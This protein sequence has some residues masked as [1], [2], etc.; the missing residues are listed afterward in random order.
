MKNFND[1]LKMNSFDNIN[2]DKT[3]NLYLEG[4][5]SE[6]QWE[7]YI[8]ESLNE[9]LNENLISDWYGQMKTWVTEKIIP[10]LKSFYEKIMNNTAGAYLKLKSFLDTI[11]GYIDKFKKNHPILF[12]VIIFIIIVIL[13][14]ILLI[15]T[16]KQAS[17]GEPA[18]NSAMM[19]D[20]AN[21][22]INN[23][24]NDP[25]VGTDKNLLLHAQAYCADMKDGILGNQGVDWGKE[26]LPKIKEIVDMATKS[27]N[28]LSQQALQGDKG[29]AD[30][31]IKMVEQG[32]Q[33]MNFVHEHIGNI[34][35]I[36]F[37][38]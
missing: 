12:K 20:Y 17:A 18:K 5:I 10:S 14:M 3:T 22:L 37:L 16:S 35:K 2:S 36:A 1:F 34:Q 9:N 26:N 13:V 30:F 29:K 32:Q 4:L 15:L 33:F 8:F 23:L 25:T 7:K 27:F 28:E 11:L 38:K 6:P 19:W 21:G 24:V 31:I